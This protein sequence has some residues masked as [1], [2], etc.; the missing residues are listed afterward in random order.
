MNNS[1]FLELEE[2][3]KR[4]PH[5]DK[6]AF[7][8]FVMEVANVLAGLIPA[9]HFRE[10]DYSPGYQT[11][12]LTFLGGGTL[13]AAIDEFSKHLDS[14]E[15]SL[16]TKKAYISD[17]R[18]VLN[19]IVE[20][21]FG[22]ECSLDSVMVAEITKVHIE[23]VENW[24]FDES[25][26]RPKTR[27]RIKQGWNAFCDFAGMKEWKMTKKTNVSCDYPDGG[28]SNAE[29]V[30]MLKYCHGQV[31]Q[32]KSSAEKI[33]F[34]RMIVAINLGWAEGL[35]SCEYR[36]ANFREA[37]IHGRI[38]IRGSKNNG[39]RV[40][41]LSSQTRQAIL[42]L[43]ELMVEANLYPQNDGVF[44]KPNGQNYT[45]RTFQRWLKKVAKDCKVPVHLAKTHGL[46]HGFVR[47]FLD[48]VKNPFMAS[49]A[50]GHQSVETTKDY[51]RPTFEELRIAMQ[52]STNCARGVL[53]PV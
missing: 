27:R 41:P 20:R 43:K 34:Q 5:D 30:E 6:A 51:G 19:A 53:K 23:R 39:E 8:G 1:I 33:R 35:R 32:A 52:Y 17:T 42:K 48:F 13:E 37:E 26:H 9:G 31:A 4:T 47:N 40:L 36:N 25:G 3:K 18:K 12:S 28:L 24:L 29:L 16:G 46:R 11:E 22:V 14:S 49:E 50:A 21:F 44:E 7:W 38:I 2:S 15:K 10:I 45:T